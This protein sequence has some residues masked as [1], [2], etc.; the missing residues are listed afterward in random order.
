MEYILFSIFLVAFI[1]TFIATKIWIYVAHKEKLLVKDM[2]KPKYPLVPKSGG[3]AVLA[4][5]IAG[6]LF[7]IGFST[8]Y[9]HRTINLIDIFALLTTCLIISF[10]GMLD[11]FVGGWKKGFKQWHKPL[12]T[13]P[14]AL[15]LMVINA[16]QTTMLFPIFGLINL[17]LLYPLLFIPAGVVGASQGFNMLAGL[18]GLEAGMASIILFALGYIAWQLGK[19]WLAI[20][21]IT[22]VAALLA[23]L[24]FNKYPSKVFTGDVLLYPLGAL[25]ACIAILGNMERAALILFIPYFI[26]FVIKAKYKFKSECFLIPQR[27]GSLEPSGKYGSITH[28]IGAIIKKIKGKVYESDIVLFL[29]ISELILAS[30]VI[31]Y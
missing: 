18:N 8:F 10:I 17:G 30:F 4:G 9:F 2:N 24:I 3:I 29:F 26:E 6:V 25:I 31:L 27:D 23:F 1:C 11:D 15:P 14:A 13:L 28:I 20:I 5:F 7:Y 12:L 21:A 16:G 22:M 19:S